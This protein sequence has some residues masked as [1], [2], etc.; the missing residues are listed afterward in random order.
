MSGLKSILVHVDASPASQQ[1]LR[2]AAKVG[3]SHEAEVTALY[4]V[5]SLGAVYPY[6]YVVGSPDSVALLSDMENANLAAARTVV[7]GVAAQNPHVH[8]AASSAEPTRAMARQACYADLLV[9]GQADPAKPADACLPTHFV[10]SVLIDSGRAALVIPRCGEF[11]SIGKVALIAWKNTREAAHAVSAALP[12]LQRCERVH[13]VSWNETDES[14]NDEPLDIERYLQLHGIACSLHGAGAV[15]D[16]VGDALLS[17]AANTS[18]DLL[19][20]GCFGHSR[21]REWVLGGA[22]RSILSSMTL[23]VLMAH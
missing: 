1:R 20:M 11:E 23:P 21:A 14:A 6:V 10:E 3:R 22:T 4:A 7:D 2:I 18:A 5:D 15:P 13:V 12:F 19:V 16:S 8:W 17:L 9:L